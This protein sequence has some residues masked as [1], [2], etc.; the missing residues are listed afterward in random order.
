MGE[1]SADSGVG[2]F[3]FGGG[4]VFSA[5]DL[6]GLLGEEVGEVIEG[7]EAGAVGE[8]LYGGTGGMEELM[9]GLL[10]FGEGVCISE[11]L[12]EFFEVVWFPIVDEVESAVLLSGGGPFEGDEEREGDFSAGEV[13]A[14]GFSGGGFGGEEVEAIVVDLV[15]DS[16]V[17]SEVFEG[18][19]L[20]GGGAAQGGAEFA[21]QGEQFGGFHGEDAEV[22]LAGGG[23]LGAAESLEDFAG[24]DGFCGI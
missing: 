23:F 6:G 9:D 4:G 16:E 19:G 10:G 24:A 20:G 8:V 1:L 15:G 17:E 18:L 22:I 2:A 12:E 21:G 7:V 13:T 14:Y 11:D 5:T 3:I